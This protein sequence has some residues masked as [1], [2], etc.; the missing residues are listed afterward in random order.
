MFR[1]REGIKAGDPLGFAA[2]DPAARK[3]MQACQGFVDCCRLALQ[4]EKGKRVGAEGWK[5]WAARQG[6][7]G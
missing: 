4:K 6:W 5:A 3:R 7:G 2:M 1:L